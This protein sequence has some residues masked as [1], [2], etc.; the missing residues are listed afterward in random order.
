LEAQI[1]AETDKEKKKDL[2]KK[3]SELKKQKEMR[4]RQ[5]YTKWLE[6]KNSKLSSVIA[7]LAQN[8]FDFNKLDSVQQQGIINIL[9]QSKLDDLTKNKV[10]ELLKI[11]QA[12]FSKFVKDLFDLNKKQILIPTKTGNYPV[13][14]KS[15]SFISSDL[16]SFFSI[17]NLD[18]LDNLPLNFEVDVNESNRDFFEKSPLFNHLF[19]DFDSKS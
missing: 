3:K 11:D 18:Q 8:N 14:F 15:K 10:P 7:K 13:N 12:D 17:D 19:Q 9:V 16:S 1:A 4:K 2:K 6:S 5:A